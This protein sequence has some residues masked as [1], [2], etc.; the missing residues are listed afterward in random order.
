MENFI[1]A[2]LMA[3]QWSLPA[4]ERISVSLYNL[5]VN[6]LTKMCLYLCL[7]SP[8]QAMRSR[9]AVGMGIPMGIPM[10]MGMGWVWGLKFNPHVSPVR[11]GGD[12][13]PCLSRCP[14]LSKAEA[15]YDRARSVAGP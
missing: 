13:L 15:S 6:N 8:Q 5:I 10:G 4:H 2:K 11:G 9:S 1:S 3:W 7:R 14:M 12:V